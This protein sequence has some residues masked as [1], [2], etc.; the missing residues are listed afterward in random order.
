MIVERS[1]G[2]PGFW[3]DLSPYGITDIEDSIVKVIFGFSN[4]LCNDIVGI[5]EPLYDAT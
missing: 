5:V 3:F 4:P 1:L 2:D